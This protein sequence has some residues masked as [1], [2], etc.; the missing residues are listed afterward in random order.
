MNPDS[1]AQNES[2]DV[3]FPFRCSPIPPCTTPL[4]TEVSGVGVIGSTRNGRCDTKYPSVRCHR[5]VREDTG[6]RREGSVGV[7]TVTN[8]AVGSTRTCRI[9]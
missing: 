9:M 2:E 8:E 7:W 5:M 6:A 4:Q 1:N 3:I